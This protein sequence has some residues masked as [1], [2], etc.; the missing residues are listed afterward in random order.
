MPAHQSLG[1]SAHLSVC[2]QRVSRDVGMLLIDE[3]CVCTA[4]RTAQAGVMHGR[5]D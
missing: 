5:V 4:R 1:P 2:L 3:Y